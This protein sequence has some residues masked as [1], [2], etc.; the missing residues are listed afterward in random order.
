MRTWRGAGFSNSIVFSRYSLRLMVGWCR[1][2]AT[3][4]IRLSIARQ[5]WSPK[6]D[7]WARGGVLPRSCG[8]SRRPSKIVEIIS[9]YRGHRECRD[10]AGSGHTPPDVVRDLGGAN[11]LSTAP[12]RHRPRIRG[13]AR[14]GKEDRVSP[15][16]RGMARCEVPAAGR[17]PRALDDPGCQKPKPSHPPHVTAGKKALQLAYADSDLQVGLMVGKRKKFLFLAS[18]LRRPAA[19]T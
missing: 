19:T 16:G 7:E 18:S 17:G 4:K 11:P 8:Q 12:R 15:L 2:V 3:E 10:R 9:A 14:I 1:L 13:A 5:P 6:L